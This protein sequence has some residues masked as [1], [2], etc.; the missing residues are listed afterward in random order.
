MNL[1]RCVRDNEILLFNKSCSLLQYYNN[2]S[3]KNYVNKYITKHGLELKL[4]FYYCKNIIDV[5]KLKTTYELHFNSCPNIKNISVLNLTRVLTINH[6]KNIKDI[7]NLKLLFI[8]YSHCVHDIYGFHLLKKIEIIY[9]YKT[10][11]NNKIK[12][13]DKYKKLQDID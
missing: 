1:T 12:K 13:L 10:V 8:L 4:S 3:Y 9:K 5:G 6:C 7:G 11:F 2:K